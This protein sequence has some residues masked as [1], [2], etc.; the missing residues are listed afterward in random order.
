MAVAVKT[1][2]DGAWTPV[3]APVGLAPRTV[4]TEPRDPRSPRAHRRLHR[5]RRDPGESRADPEVEA[6]FQLEVAGEGVRFVDPSAGPTPEGTA[7]RTR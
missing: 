7:R 5:H 1:P 6:T 4:G 3:G 2:P